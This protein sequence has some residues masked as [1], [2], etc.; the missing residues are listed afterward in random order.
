MLIFIMILHHIND[1]LFWNIYVWQTNLEIFNLDF[2]T[3]ELVSSI[4]TKNVNI[5]ATFNDRDDIYMLI[6]SGYLT[7]K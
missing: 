2:L 4:W 7:A 1:V 5:G 6:Y 3:S